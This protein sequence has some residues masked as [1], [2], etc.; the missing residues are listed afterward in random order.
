MKIHNLTRR[1]KQWTF[2]TGAIT[3]YTDKN[4]NGLYYDHSATGKCET[5]T[6]NFKASRCR[7]VTLWKLNK[8]FR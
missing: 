1:G 4:G 7:L 6:H 5:L 2:L 3:Y 8:I